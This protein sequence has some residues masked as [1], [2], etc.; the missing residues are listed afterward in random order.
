MAN[1]DGCPYGEIKI[2][3]KCTG[4]NHIRLK[5]DIGL[6]ASKKFIEKYK[7]NPTEL[8]LTNCFKNNARKVFDVKVIK[9]KQWKAF[10]D[11]ETMD[12][13]G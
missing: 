12:I 7:K 9:P 2:D 8:V 13:K 3:G 4:E 6:R 5:I 1:K 11:N 10:R